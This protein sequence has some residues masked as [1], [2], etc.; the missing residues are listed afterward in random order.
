MAGDI[1]A[2]FAKMA[3]DVAQTG[4][5]AAADAAGNRFIALTLPHVPARSGA[6]RRSIRLHGGGGGTRSTSSAAPHTVYAAIQNFGGTIHVKHTYTTKGG[7]T[8][9]G[10]LSNGESFF[11]RQVTIPG[12]HYWDLAGKEGAITAAAD[13]AI[14]AIIDGAA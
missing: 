14:Q 6:L 10:F 4:A 13:H 2:L 7:K 5:K 3:A 1:G 12:H 9:P 11:G 8:L